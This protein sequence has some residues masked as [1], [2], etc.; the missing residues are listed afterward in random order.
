MIAHSFDFYIYIFLRCSTYI[1]FR[2]SIIV[3]FRDFQWCPGVWKIE[4]WTIIEN[5]HWKIIIVSSQWEMRFAS[6]C[7]WQFSKR[8]G[9]SPLSFKMIHLKSSESSWGFLNINWLIGGLEHVWNIFH[10]ILGMSSSQLTFIFFRGVWNN[11]QP[12]GLFLDFRSASG[13]VCASVGGGD[14]GLVGCWAASGVK[15]DLVTSLDLSDGTMKKS[16][17]D[18]GKVGIR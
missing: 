12:V 15:L 2:H 3:T 6:L 18:Y 16:G 5:H 10:N 13:E 7:G 17:F 8:A 1:S 4:M 11:H 14:A 9:I